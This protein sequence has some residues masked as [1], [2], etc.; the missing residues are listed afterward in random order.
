MEAD[1]VLSDDEGTLNGMVIVEGKVL[2]AELVAQV[3]ERV[4][5][6]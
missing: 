3:S 1:N 5:H 6:E 2:I 4:C